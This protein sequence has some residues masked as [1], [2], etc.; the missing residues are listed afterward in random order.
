MLRLMTSA[1]EAAYSMARMAVKAS[2][3]PPDV[4]VTGRILT[5]GATPSMSRP[6]SSWAAMMPATKVPCHMSTPFSLLPKSR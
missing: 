3:T 5:S 2:D 4:M 6:L 1:R